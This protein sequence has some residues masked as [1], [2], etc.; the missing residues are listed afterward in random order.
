MDR[1]RH[2]GQVV[3]FLVIALSAGAFGAGPPAAPARAERLAALVAWP[4]STVLVSEVMT[5]GTSASD[6][7]AEI[8]NAGARPDRP[9]GPRTG[10]RDLDRQ[11][12]HPKGG[13][14]DA[15]DPGARPASPR[16]EC[17]GDPRGHWQ[18]P[19]TAADS[20]LPAAPWSSDRSEANRSMPW[21]GATRAASLSRERPR[22]RRQADRASSACRVARSATVRIRTTIRPISLPGLR[23]FPRIS[24]R[25][26]RHCPRQ[27]PY[28]RRRPA[29]CRRRR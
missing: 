1:V 5:G 26:R 10:L 14:V 24:L 23:R 19:R 2:A 18:T 28:P 21:A 15:D 27:R 20:P 4:T 3:L 13:V 17:V 16:G 6:E 12:G 11:H 8:T 25:R 22:P 7:F 9:D 29:R